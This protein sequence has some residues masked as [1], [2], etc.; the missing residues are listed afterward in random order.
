MR[1][2]AVN[3]MVGMLCLLVAA[4]ALWTNLI[5][6]PHPRVIALAVASALVAVGAVGLVL[7]SRNRNERKPR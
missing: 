5:G 2:N 1:S 7:T 3:V 4:A 6:V